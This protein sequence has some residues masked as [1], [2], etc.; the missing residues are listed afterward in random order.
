MPCSSEKMEAH[1]DRETAEA[2]RRLCLRKK[3]NPSMVG[4]G[5]NYGKNKL[6]A[7]TI[8]SNDVTKSQQAGGAPAYFR[9]LGELVKG[10]KGPQSAPLV[11]LLHRLGS[12]ITSI[13]HPSTH[14][15]NP[16]HPD[17]QSFPKVRD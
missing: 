11:L 10:A 15:P 5:G 7:C 17:T 2:G 1:G 12:Q 8:L 14:H 3:E 4:S 6:A 16:P 13:R 9:G